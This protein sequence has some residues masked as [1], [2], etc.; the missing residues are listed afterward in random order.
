MNSAQLNQAGISSPAFKLMF[1]CR[2]HIGQG[3]WADTKRRRSVLA[4]YRAA[5]KMGHAVASQAQGAPNPDW[6]I[7]YLYKFPL[8]CIVTSTSENIDNPQPSHF[9]PEAAKVHHESNDFLWVV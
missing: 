8:H 3:L 7:T 2:L 9:V 4:L 6:S 1:A 5:S